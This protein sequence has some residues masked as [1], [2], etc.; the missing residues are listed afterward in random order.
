MAKRDAVATPIEIGSLDIT[1][2]VQLVA[3]AEINP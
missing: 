3:I 2:R 1:S